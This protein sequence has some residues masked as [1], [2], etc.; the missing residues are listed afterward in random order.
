MTNNCLN[1]DDLK[2]MLDID[3]FNKMIKNTNEITNEILEDHYKNQ[4]ND[5]KAVQMQQRKTAQFQNTR[6]N[7]EEKESELI[8]RQEEI[9]ENL[10]R[11]NGYL[12]QQ[13]VYEE[14]MMF[15]LKKIK[16]ENTF[17]KK[18]I[19]SQINTINISNRKSYFEN[20]ENDTAT[21]WANLFKE[22]YWMLVLLLVIGIIMSKKYNEIKLWIMVGILAFFPFLSYFIIRLL[23]GI[24]NWIM[25]ETKWVYLYSNM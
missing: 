7:I 23:I 20:E 9:Y 17:L 11:L 16:R 3:L 18:D 4:R 10:L 14:N 19:K 21:W 25:S 5:M 13:D 12:E 22:K 15:L 2:N 6:T 8:K 24:Y 1:E